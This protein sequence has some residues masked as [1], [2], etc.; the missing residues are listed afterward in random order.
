MLLNELFYRF[1]HKIYFQGFTEYIR[2]YLLCESIQDG[3]EITEAIVQRNVCNIREKNAPWAMRFKFTMEKVV[4]HTA[5]FHRLCHT[6]VGVCFSEWAEQSVFPHKTS[7]FLWIHDDWW[8]Q[9]EQAHI[10][11]S[12]SF[13]IPS[14]SI[15]FQ[16]QLKNPPN[17]ESLFSLLFRRLQAS[18]NIRIWRLR[19]FGIAHLRSAGFHLPPACHERSQICSLENP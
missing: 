10:D 12:Y 7:Y 8:V 6:S 5:G 19:Q 17:P 11:S 2:Q 1:N 16:N 15:R 4:R 9:M 3:R 13:V 18:C 14:E